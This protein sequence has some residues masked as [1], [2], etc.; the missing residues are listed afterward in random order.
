MRIHGD[1][2][3]FPD[4]T[5][6]FTASTGGG[7]T[8]TPPVAFNL[9]ISSGLQMSDGT[10][11]RFQII[12]DEATIDTA[13][14]H[15]GSGYVVQ[16]TGIYNL[17][18]KINAYRNV[19]LEQAIAYLEL[20]GEFVSNTRFLN[21][22]TAKASGLAPSGTWV[23]T[24]NKGDVVV[25]SAIVSSSSAPTG[26][27]IDITGGKYTTLSGHMISSITEGEVKEKEA[28]VFKAGLSANQLGI[29]HSVWAKVKLDTIFTDEEGKKYG[30]C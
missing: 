21:P 1:K 11:N 19:N 22:S 15:D 6:Q 3:E 23:G 7:G 10:N 9:Q 28:V 14:G 27:P 29:T 12:L 2:I 5:E 16:Q 24:L 18:Y 13:N 25:L 4:G 30:R 26:S 17:S 8:A 20:N